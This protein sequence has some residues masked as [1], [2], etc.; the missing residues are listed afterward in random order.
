[1]RVKQIKLKTNN[2]SPKLLNYWLKG[3]VKEIIVKT[4][5]PTKIYTK[6]DGGY[7]LKDRNSKIN[8]NKLNIN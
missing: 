5:D 3:E 1:M 4:T 7:K 8:I 2:D 6:S